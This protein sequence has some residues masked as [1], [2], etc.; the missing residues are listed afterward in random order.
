MPRTHYMPGTVRPDQA[1][2]LAVLSKLVHD[3]IEVSP[4]GRLP[5]MPQWRVPPADMAKPKPWRRGTGHDPKL[6]PGEHVW[7]CV[8]AV[9]TCENGWPYLVVFVDHPESDFDERYEYRMWPGEI[10]YEPRRREN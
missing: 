1:G 2:L 9:G 10:S 5:V 4:K 3:W 8:K 7:F 6:R